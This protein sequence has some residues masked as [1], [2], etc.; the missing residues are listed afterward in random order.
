MTS[1]FSP[2]SNSGSQVESRGLSLGKSKAQPEAGTQPAN[3]VK[4]TATNPSAEP[5]KDSD[6]R[7]VFVLDRFNDKEVDIDG[8]KKADA[9][10]GEVIARGLQNEGFDVDRVQQT[11]QVGSDLSNLADSFDNG[12]RSFRQGDVVNVSSGRADDPTFKELSGIVG[13][14]VTPD[15]IASQRGQIFDALKKQPPDSRT[16]DWLKTNDAIERMQ[17]KGLE[18]VHAAGNAGPDRVSVGFLNANHQLSATDA[19][20]QVQP[21]SANSSVTKPAQGIQPISE[22]KDANGNVTG[23]DVGR[24]GTVDF[25]AN[26]VSGG[27]QFVDQFE[28]KP[29]SAVSDRN[30]TALADVG[31]KFKNSLLPISQIPE[32]QIL[33]GDGK[34]GAFVNPDDTHPSF[35]FRQNPNGNLFHDP[36]N[37]GNPGSVNAILGTSFSVLAYLRNNL[38]PQ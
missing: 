20:G 9:A 16:Q 17:G 38:P 2:A 34:D 5:R 3:P 4:D 24:D 37:S 33:W 23:F 10:H 25:K 26:E 31:D 29:A 15:N 6:P 8:D 7:K 13:F 28:G 36:D 19:R 32:G 11:G 22:V 27:P 30:G 12:S 21:W 18:V 35:V 14:P 1:A